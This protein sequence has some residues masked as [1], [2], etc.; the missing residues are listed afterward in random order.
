MNKITVYR[1]QV[2]DV[3]TRKS[4][5]ASRWGTREAIE[6]VRGSKVWEETATE[7]DVL[8]LNAD[9]MIGVSSRHPAKTPVTFPILS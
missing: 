8:D 3:V 5:V 9:G 7:V 6:R 1:F 2:Y 4:A